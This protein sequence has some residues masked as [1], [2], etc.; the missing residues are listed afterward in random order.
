[1]K[2]L[3]KKLY[4]EEHPNFVFDPANYDKSVDC[5]MSFLPVKQKGM[6]RI[7]DIIT[8]AAFSIIILG[9]TLWFVLLPDQEF[10]ADEN[11]YLQT[12]PEVS[13]KTITEGT[14]MREMASYYADQF[15]LRAEFIQLK[16]AS[17]ILLQ[18]G[19]NKNVL[20]GSD[21]YLLQRFDVYDDIEGDMDD[22]FTKAEQL[23]L[24]QSNL[25]GAAKLAGAIDIPMVFAAP[26]R[27]IDVMESVLPDFYP[28]G[29]YADWYTGLTEELLDQAIPENPKTP[30]IFDMTPFL[31]ETLLVHNEEYIFYKTDHH[32]TARGAFHAY[33]IL[34]DVLL[35][36]NAPTI[37]TMTE[38]YEVHTLSEE[39]YGTTWS[40]AGKRW[41]APDT[42]ELWTS[43]LQ[44][45]AN[46]AA[47]V[48]VVTEIEG[49]KTFYGLIDEEALGKKD[50]YAALIGGI[51]PVS[52]IY[53]A[54]KGLDNPTFPQ[55]AIYDKP[56]LLLICDSY[57]QALAPYLVDDFNLTIIDM[58]FYGKSVKKYIDENAVDMVLVLQNMES[59]TTQNNLIGLGLGLD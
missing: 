18:R 23:A 11:R 59:L 22:S 10:S 51:N 45:E 4:T 29:K 12:A 16:V 33:D 56:H 58:R 25:T 20:F 7:V 9:L 32:W 28:K 40:K 30:Y 47:N 13:L 48:D 14:F 39:F 27:K 15:P 19:Q 38:H 42:I 49:K 6:P 41:V 36:P 55:N 21:G 2:N 53:Y 46:S 34:R 57:G 35:Q 54:E 37:S 1:M 50:K 44:A 26:P 8:C 52:H 3:F 43:K 17:E 5:S 24:L 31:Y